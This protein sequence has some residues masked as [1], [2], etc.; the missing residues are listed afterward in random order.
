MSPRYAT[1]RTAALLATLAFLAAPAPRAQRAAPALDL[2]ARAA[3]SAPGHVGTWWEGTLSTIQFYDPTTGHWAAPNGVGTFLTLN[4]DGSFRAGGVLNVT[5]GYCTSTLM[6]DERGTYAASADSLVLRRQ[7][8]NSRMTNTCWSD[9]ATRVLEPE[10]QRF[11]LALGADAQGRETLVRTRSDEAHSTMRRMSGAGGEEPP[12]AGG[13]VA[14]RHFDPAGEQLTSLIDQVAPLD[15]GFVFGTNVWRDDEKAVL[16]TLPEGVGEA[17]LVEVDVYFAHRNA[18][19]LIYDVSVHAET[20]EG[21]PIGDPLSSE[22]FAFSDIQIDGDPTTPS[23]PTVHRL[24]E[25]V[26]VGRTFFVSVS[27]GAGTF[28][29][30]GDLAIAHAPMLPRRVPE[31]WEQWADL[32]W[33]NA[34][35]TWWGDGSAGSGTQGAHLWVE[36]RVRPV[37]GTAGEPDA[38]GA[39]AAL[40]L[41]APAPNPTGGWTRLSLALR[42]A[43]PVTVEAF[44]V[45]GRRVAVL[46]D[47]PAPAGALPITLD[48][49]ALPAGAYV[50]R[51]TGAGGAASRLVTVVR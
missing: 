24:E 2:A 50:V 5:S 26:R 19:R 30:P 7:S 34:S 20:A 3:A 42:E 33:H 16:F 48:A 4:A 49:A 29:D 46:H 13:L 9:V 36:A 45:L 39:D 21:G 28:G 47:G 41:S 43:G 25:P 22:S 14:L 51:A 17:D 11:G 44:D 37:G 10:T 32:T 6:V 23:P 8:G 18:G 35:D 1:P 12:P 15:T 31:V 27:G 40:A 38:P